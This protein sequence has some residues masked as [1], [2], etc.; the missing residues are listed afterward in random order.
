M[1]YH[2]MHNTYQDNNYERENVH[3]NL[4]TVLLD[5]KAVGKLFLCMF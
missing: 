5:P 1:K 3:E 2:K 4:Q